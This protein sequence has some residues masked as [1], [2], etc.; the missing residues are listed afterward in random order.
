MKEQFFS[1]YLLHKYSAACVVSDPVSTY[2]WLV[3]TFHVLP[4]GPI[5][6]YAMSTNS[7]D[8][9][10]HTSDKKYGF[11]LPFKVLTKLV[12]LWMYDWIVQMFVVW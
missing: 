7:D 6:W 10:I 1:R 8:K 9:Y 11:G 4:L 5:S 2:S 12:V 3:H